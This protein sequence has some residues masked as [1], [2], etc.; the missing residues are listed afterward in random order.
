MF[1]FVYDP[2]MEGVGA[3]DSETWREWLKKDFKGE[4]RDEE[5]SQAVSKGVGKT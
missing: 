1:H 3:G 5:M 2:R 4:T